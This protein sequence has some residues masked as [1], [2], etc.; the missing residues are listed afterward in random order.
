MRDC[1]RARMRRTSCVADLA[2]SPV[3]VPR[4]IFFSGMAALRHCV[5]PPLAA[6]ALARGAASLSPGWRIARAACST[7]AAAQFAKTIPSASA[8]AKTFSVAARLGSGLLALRPATASTSSASVRPGACVGLGDDGRAAILC[9]RSGL[10]ISAPLDAGAPPPAAGAE[11][12]L[13]GGE[14]LSLRVSAAL[15]RCAAP[16]TCAR[17]ASSLRAVGARASRRC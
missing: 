8:P 9:W 15:G 16:P 4:R 2:R 6:T 1:G 12:G 11:L 17:R 10:A 13:L 7:S 14:P 3:G 5:P